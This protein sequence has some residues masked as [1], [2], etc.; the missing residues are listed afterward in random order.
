MWRF[1]RYLLS[2]FTSLDACI[3][4]RKS[5]YWLKASVQSIS[6]RRITRTVLEW[7]DMFENLLN[8][9]AKHT[10]S[11]KKNG[12]K[13]GQ[14]VFWVAPNYV[15]RSAMPNNQFFILGLVSTIPLL[16][17]SEPLAIFRGCR[18]RFVWD[19]VGNPKDRFC[20]DAAHIWNKFL[21]SLC[22]TT[23]QIGQLT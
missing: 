20:H 23:G 8:R 19:L 16:P 9:N 17:K 21:P 4:L 6:S 3:H 22:N 18:A 12:S 13:T 5:L 14:K 7:T 11:K 1:A 10:E 2:R 15:S